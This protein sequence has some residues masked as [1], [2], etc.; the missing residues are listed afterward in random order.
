MRLL[1]WTGEGGKPAYLSTDDEGSY[2]S[3]LA[4]NLE[5][6]QLGMAE[7]LLSHV[8]KTMT[9][10]RPSATELRSIITHL[11]QALRDGLRVAH[12]RGDRLPLPDDEDKEL[13]VE[14]D[15]VIERA[16]IR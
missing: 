13:T 3:Q 11:S 6:V 8:Q 4:D 7:D 15:A 1:P 12:S 10:E 16:V 14:T 5:A 9:E 2:L